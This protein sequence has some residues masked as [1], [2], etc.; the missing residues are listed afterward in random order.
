MRTV[1]HIE[2][3]DY[4]T[5]EED[6]ND[7][8]EKHAAGMARVEGLIVKARLLTN[9]GRLEEAMDSLTDAAHLNME[10]PDQEKGTLA[11]IVHEL[12]LDHRADP[13]LSVVRG[14]LGEGYRKVYEKER[15]LLLE[16]PLS[17]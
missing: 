16:L 2:R 9:T 17:D 7:Y 11:E 5:A 12:L 3:W 14:S 4:A 10:I 8:L 15:R 13:K 6:I 1:G